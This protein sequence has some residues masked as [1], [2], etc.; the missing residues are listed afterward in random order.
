MNHKL[1]MR[2]PWPGRFLNDKKEKENNFERTTENILLNS[3]KLHTSFIFLLGLSSVYLPP[4]S[5]NVV[6]NKFKQMRNIMEQP[7]FSIIVFGCRMA[8]GILYFSILFVLSDSEM[9]PNSFI[10]L[11]KHNR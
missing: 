1:N 4:S 8:Y 11:G 10:R 9:L 5:K 2:S 3:I 6:P 7:K